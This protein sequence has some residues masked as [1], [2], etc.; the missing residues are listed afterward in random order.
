VGWVQVTDTSSEFNE[1][2]VG[3]K[4]FN[5]RRLREKL[6]GWIHQPVSAAVPFGVFE[7]VLALDSNRTVQ[8]RYET[9]VS[10][11]ENDPSKILSDM[12]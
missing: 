2:R 4:C 6:P 7:K 11:I 10:S 3:T 12:G 9:L 8:E 1:K 5:Q